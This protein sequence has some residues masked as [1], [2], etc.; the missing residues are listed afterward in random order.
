LITCAFR[1]I[2]FLTSCQDKRVKI[3]YGKIVADGD[4][5]KREQKCRVEE[6]LQ[7]ISWTNIGV[8]F[9]GQNNILNIAIVAESN[10][11]EVISFLEG[12]DEKQTRL[13]EHGISEESK[14]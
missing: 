14:L 3:L 1:F 13:F 6:A 7:N 5:L 4:A 12:V 8:C 9:F 10:V 11:T 2:I